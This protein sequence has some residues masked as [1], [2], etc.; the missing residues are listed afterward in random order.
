MAK[1][2]VKV[3]FENGTHS[4][5]AIYNGYDGRIL[6]W[7]DIETMLSNEHLV[8]LSK[9]AEEDTMT[10]IKQRCDGT[11]LFDTREEAQKVIDAMDL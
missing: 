11:A 6:S 5:Y 8:A 4:H 2:I 3:Q 10:Q 1:E 7:V 9:T